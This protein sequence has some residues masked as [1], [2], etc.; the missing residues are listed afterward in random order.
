MIPLDILDTSPNENSN[1]DSHEDFNDENQHMIPVNDS[2]MEIEQS[3]QCSKLRCLLVFFMVTTL[4]F[5]F[6]WLSESQFSEGILRDKLL[7]EEC[8]WSFIKSRSCATPFLCRDNRCQLIINTPKYNPDD[9]SKC[10]PCRECPR[11]PRCPSC[12]N[13]V[14]YFDFNEFP[15]TYFK[16]RSQEITKIHLGMPYGGCKEVCAR[17][18]SCKAICFNGINNVCHERTTYIF[19]GNRNN[20]WNCAIKS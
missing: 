2:E 13:L 4:V 6:L 11:C 14:S 8:G 7:N 20:T 17:N 5:F 9:Y 1:E 3:I 19:P 18:P 15:N 10:P 16:Q 12:Q